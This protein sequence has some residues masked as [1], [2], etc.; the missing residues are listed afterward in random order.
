MVTAAPRLRL[1]ILGGF[2]VVSDGRFATRAPS[3][4][5]QELIAFLIL[6]ARDAPVLRQRI[7]GSLWP[8]SNDAQALTNL[9][10]ELHHLRDAWPVLEARIDAGSRT[11]AWRD[12][13]ELP[14]DL[15]AFEQ[16]AA[17]GLGGDRVA[18]Q[19]AARLYQGDLLPDVAAEWIETDREHLRRRA[20]SVLSHLIGRLEQER[21]YGDAIE[22]A[23]QLSRLDPL[24]E[25]AWCTLM[26][27]HARRGDRA[28]ALHLYQQWT[29]LLKR[30]LG[31]QP[32]AA[33]RLTYREILDLE[34]APPGPA[35][36]RTSV[37]PLVGRHAEFRTLLNQ[38]Y[39]AASGRP[40]LVLIRGEAGIGKSR[41]AEELVDWCRLNAITSVTARCYAGEG[42]LAYAP[43]ASWLK[44]QSLHPALRTL[45]EAWL[46]DVARLRPELMTE[47]PDVTAPGLHLESWQRLRFFEAL[48]QAFRAA[49]PLVL[50]LDDLQWADADT[51]EWLQYF[52]RSASGSSCLVVATVRAEE[53]QDN[54]PIARLLGQ[55]GRD[56]LLTTIVLGPLDH[57]ATALLADAVAG[58]PLDD[59]A[60]ART[61]RDTEGHPLFIVERGRMELARQPGALPGGLSR[62]QAVVAARLALLSED[63]RVTVEIA[64][65][66]GRDFQF[67][68]LARASDLEEPALV[69]A[70][71]EL[72]QRHIV[73]AQAD[74]RW[75]FSHDRIREVA[76]GGIGPARRRLVHR[77]IAQAMELLF[78]GRLDEV[79][80]SL[81]VHL[82]RGGQ[83]AR[84]VPFLERA[85]AVATRVSANEEAIRC[86]THALSILQALPATRDRGERELSIRSSLSVAL[87]SARGYASTE[88]EQNLDR[89]F[90][91]S[92]ASGEGQLPVRWLWVAFTHHFML[93][94]LKATREVS[95]QALA[96]SVA[97][98]SCRCE[99]HHAMGGM[100]MSVGEL[101]A[102]RAH[103]DASLAA[104]DEQH[105]QRSALGSDL[106]VFAH[107]WYSHA[108]WLLGQEDAAVMHADEGI[109]LARRLDHLF[110][111]TIAHAYAALLHQMRGDTRRV[112]EHADGVVALCERYGFAYYGD[113]AKILIGWVRGQEQP[114]RGIELIESALKQLDA[115]RAQARRP[116]YLSLLADTYRLAGD[117]TRAASILDAAITMARERSD[118]WWLPA[119]FLQKGELDPPLE[120]DRALHAGLE[121]ARA[122]H[123]LGLLRR[124]TSAMSASV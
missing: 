37:Y 64:A 48:G 113:W 13:L 62:V 109:A 49:A 88:V 114:A 118:V 115:Q 102:A 59:A 27:C 72:W 120:R 78:A 80:A 47:R 107:A 66:V 87:N 95:E 90:A 29:A 14:V 99:A 42:R 76:Y 6:H 74:E 106:G 11:L 15:V 94:D 51:I 65:A 46:T 108:L 21:A 124:I 10:R 112:L 25:Q 33:T 111:Q 86:L 63:A 82:D 50:I 12:D 52:L 36:S 35:P 98:P 24:E 83:P 40:S 20:K 77:R 70:L 61:F 71:D 79:S 45:D 105:P 68:I 41:L 103:F 81:A 84:A 38:W 57:T 122:Q 26:R 69:R 116:Y 96:C 67:D 8:E 85:A 3:A 9:R 31:A 5:Q 58:H 23:Q 22:H 16:A 30:E 123:S 4:R 43:I 2:R 92:R 104:Y 101:G 110:S 75:D 73:R 53:E 28:T 44:S 34:G 55:L 7:A 119:L 121:M 89:V 54:P 19:D 117:R 97:D 1:E 32:N 93:G 56:D 100:L 17:R 18:L 39:A 60:Q 91:L